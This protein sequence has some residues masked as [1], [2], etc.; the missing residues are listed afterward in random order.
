MSHLLLVPAHMLLQAGGAEARRA[1]RAA[2]WRQMGGPRLAALPG[3]S[4]RQSACRSKAA[5]L[6]Q[7]CRRILG[8][9]KTWQQRHSIHAPCRCAAISSK[10]GELK[11]A[12][13]GS[14]VLSCCAQ[15]LLFPATL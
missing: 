3:Q 11:Q 15:P 5:L 1:R 9:A 6:G 14:F 7:R 8:M 2:S 4:M 12:F 13:E 10:L